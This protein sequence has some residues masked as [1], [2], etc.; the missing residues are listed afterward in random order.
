MRVKINDTELTLFEGAR[1]KDAIQSY[2][3]IT[4]RRFGFKS[5]MVVNSEGFEMLPDGALSDGICLLTK[6]RPNEPKSN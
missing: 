4:G 1:L 6:P 3:T 2:K 5:S